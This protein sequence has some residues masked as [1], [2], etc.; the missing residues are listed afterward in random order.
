MSIRCIDK[1]VWAAALLAVTGSAAGGPAVYG[2]GGR[3]CDTFLE[4]QRQ[5]DAG[6]PDAALD[7]FGYRQWLAG[8]VT[9]LS[10]AAGEDVLRGVDVEGL[11]R[12]VRLNCE[13]DRTLDVLGAALAHIKE[14]SRL[15]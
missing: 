11:A 13:E 2:Y 12:R 9:G 15:P 7:D 8:L 3:D 10:L 4:S 5:A 1:G 14:L 6:E